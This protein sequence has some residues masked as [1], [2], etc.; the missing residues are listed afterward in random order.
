ML[1][2]ITYILLFAVST[3]I[4][5][6]W[7][8]LKSRNKE[9]ELFTSLLLKCEKEISSALKKHPDGM[10]QKEFE[11]KIKGVHSSLFYSKTQAVVHDAAA[12][13][14]T[15]IKN[16]IDR[17]IIVEKKKNGTARYYLKS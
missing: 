3:A 8:L 12:F 6:T 7:G 11:E 2:T 4:L 13:S 5:Y 1:N 17:N 9:N 14:G 16:M 10:T 15:L